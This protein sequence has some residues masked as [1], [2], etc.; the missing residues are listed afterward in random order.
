MSRPTPEESLCP[1]HGHYMTAA[2][3]AVMFS[4]GSVGQDFRQ[5]TIKMASL[6]SIMSGNQLIRC[7]GLKETRMAEV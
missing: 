7:K 2:A 5:G 6:C 4:L 1:S 3:P